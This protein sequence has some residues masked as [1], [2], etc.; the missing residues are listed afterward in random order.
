MRDIKIQVIFNI[1]GRDFKPEIKHHYTSV[2]RLCN[3]QDMFDYKNTE[4]IAKRQFTGVKDIEDKEIY[5][6]DIIPLGLIIWHEDELAFCVENGGDMSL[7]SN[8]RHLLVI[9]NIHQNP[10]LLETK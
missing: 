10:E 9:G 3:N 7:L 4:V 6:G 8:V 2:N 1:H 5:E